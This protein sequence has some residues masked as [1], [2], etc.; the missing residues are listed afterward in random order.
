MP[1]WN[2]G[3]I[4]GAG[5]PPQMEGMPIQQRMAQGYSPPPTPTIPY[6]A[7]AQQQ[8]GN[9]WKHPQN[10][11]RQYQQLQSLPPNVNPPEWLDP[12]SVN[13]AYQLYEYHN[14]GRPWWE[15]EKPDDPMFD[16][17]FES[18]PAPPLYRAQTFY[19]GYQTEWPYPAQEQQIRRYEYLDRTRQL[20]PAAQEP[21]PTA[22]ELQYG[23][24]EDVW[25]QLPLY[26]KALL[27]LF[28]GGSTPWTDPL[29]KN[30]P[31]SVQQHITPGAKVGATLGLVMG[32]GNPFGALMGGALGSAMERHPTIASIMQYL[33][34][35]AQ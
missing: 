33:D 26:Q 6:Y 4:P 10:V 29:M 27:S 2:K 28:G 11:V 15:W 25:D 18:I 14:Q 5:P 1:K 30:L 34:Y 17:F 23:A 3:P 35:P 9:Y 32:A 7:Y 22:H 31:E 20:Q 16:R 19:P 13:F 24:T 12:D 21:L 8:R